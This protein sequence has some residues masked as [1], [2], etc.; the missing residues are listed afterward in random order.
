MNGEL[1]PEQLI[2]RNSL[3]KALHDLGVDI[4]I[5][6]GIALPIVAGWPLF[7]F[8]TPQRSFCRLMVGALALSDDYRG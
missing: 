8:V 3:V 6:N 4:D 1:Y 2:D 5:R 7:L